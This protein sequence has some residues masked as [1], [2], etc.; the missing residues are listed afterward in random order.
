MRMT[1]QTGTV[2]V[3]AGSFHC[4]QTGLAPTSLSGMSGRAAFLLSAAALLLLPAILN[5]PITVFL[6]VERT[7]GAD[8]LVRPEI[9]VY[10]V[11]CD[12]TLRAIRDWI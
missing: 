3:R 10:R 11:N 2:P 7:W 5:R 9:A 1:D 6:M 12:D 8:S 4:G